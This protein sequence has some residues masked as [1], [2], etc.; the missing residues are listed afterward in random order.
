MILF[1]N[2][3]CLGLFSI[4]DARWLWYTIQHIWTMNFS[5][6][7]GSRHSF[8]SLCEHQTLL[9]FISHSQPWIISKH[10]H[11]GEYLGEHSMEKFMQLFGVLS[12]WL[13]FLWYSAPRTPDALVLLEHSSVPFY[14]LFYYSWFTSWRF[15]LYRKMT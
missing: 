8:R 13:S 10:A 3:K 9:L 2:S 6:C 11:L 12:P 1:W 7:G 4:A 5:D 14:V 15:L